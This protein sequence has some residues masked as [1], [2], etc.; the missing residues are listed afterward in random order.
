MK[1]VIKGEKFIEHAGWLGR[2]WSISSVSRNLQLWNML[3]NYQGKVDLAFA[4]MMWRFPG[5]PPPYPLDEAAYESSQGKGWDAKIC[6]LA[7]RRIGIMLPDDGDSGL[8]YICTGP[9]SQIAYPLKPTGCDWY[10]T[11]G[12][13][14]FYQV[15]LASGPAAVVEAAKSEAH[16]CIAS[17]YRELMMVNYT[18]PK[19]AVLN[20]LYSRA[21]AE[22]YEGLAARNKGAL[23]T[24]NEALRY[25]AH[26]ATAFTRSQAHSKKAYNALVPPATRPEDLDLKPYGGPWAKWAM[27]T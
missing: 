21:N 13:H 18:D 23:A 11:A 10:Q 27:I 12:T 7:S 9:A 19:Y 26:A 2:G 14:T 24:G 6:T 4:K 16:A 8:A 15:A 3:S 5:N 20:A 1:A 17:A 25:F 22:Y